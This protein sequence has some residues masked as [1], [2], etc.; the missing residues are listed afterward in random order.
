MHSQVN[1]LSEVDE[2]AG[3]L[4]MFMLTELISAELIEP[5]EIGIRCSG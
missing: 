2:Q 5:E 3:A 4:E 1:G